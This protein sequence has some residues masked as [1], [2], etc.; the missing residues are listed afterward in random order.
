MLTFGGKFLRLTYLRLRFGFLSVLNHRPASSL[1][2]VSAFLAMLSA[3]T[4]LPSLSASS[5]CWRN[6]FASLYAFLRSLLS[7]PKFTEFSVLRA[8]SIMVRTV[9][10]APL[11][12]AVWGVRNWAG[13]DTGAGGSAAGGGSTG[14]A[15]PGFASAAFGSGFGGASRVRPDRGGVTGAGVPLGAGKSATGSGGNSV[16][17]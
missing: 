2:R 3:K 9:L 7:G 6:S 10:A 14:L 13:G 8:L 4:R 5:A 11:V 17:G 16:P 15:S 12:S 1:A